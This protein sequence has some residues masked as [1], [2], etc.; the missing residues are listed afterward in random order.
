MLFFPGHTPPQPRSNTRAFGKKKHL[1]VFRVCAF[2]SL[3]MI[4]AHENW[5]SEPEC[6]GRG[7]FICPAARLA[8]YFPREVC[9]EVTIAVTC[10]ELSCG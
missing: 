2:L 6:W 1:F 8:S 3:L 9:F 5:S 4:K 7:L 10:D